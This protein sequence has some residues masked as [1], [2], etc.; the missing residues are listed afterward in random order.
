VAYTVSIVTVPT[1]YVVAGPS[2]Y[3]V[4]L[5]LSGDKLSKKANLNLPLNLAPCT[6]SIGD[7]VW[8]DLDANGV[9]DAGEPPLQGVVV[10]LRTQ[11]GGLL[12]TATTDI[13]GEYTFVVTCSQ[14]YVVEVE[15]PSGFTP[16]PSGRGGNVDLDSNPSGDEV[17]VGN[18]DHITD[19]DFGFYALC[20]GSIGNFVWHDVNRDGVQDVGE[21]PGLY[22]VTI[23]LLQD[24]VVIRTAYTDAAG[25]YL[26][27]GLCPGTYEVRYDATTVPTG[28]EPT[29]GGQGTPETDSGSGQSTR[30]TIVITLNSGWSWANVPEVLKVQPFSRAPTTYVEPGSF[31][32]KFTAPNIAK[33]PATTVVFSGNRV[34]I[35]VPGNT[36]FYGIHGDV[37]R[38]LP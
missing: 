26:F 7:Y 2:S 16:S 4:E 35:T 38:E 27:E 37:L 24:G 25:Y 18:N 34:T 21:E 3:T 14:T 13:N 1:G 5:T 29:I 36:S 33:D 11:T 17:V 31:I 6:S 15:T 20:R 9:Q 22:D 28:F 30:T 10:N 32:Y 12:D 19:V 8:N 23:E